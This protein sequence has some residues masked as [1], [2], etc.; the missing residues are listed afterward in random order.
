[1]K[2]TY[3]KFFL[4]T[5]VLGMLVSS[6]NPKTPKT[7]VCIGDSITEGAGVENQSLHSFPSVLSALLGPDYAVINCGQ[8]GATMLTK[9]DLPYETTNEWY[10][11]Q[12][13]MADLA[14][15]ALG[16]NDSKDHNW[17]LDRFADNYRLM[18]ETMLRQNPEMKIYV[19]L[20]PPAFNH[21]WNIN[22]STIRN[23]VI[24]VVR[25][26]AQEM[27][28]ELI[29][30]YSPLSSRADLFPDGIHP[31]EKGYELIAKLIE[32]EIVSNS[33]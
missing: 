1:M 10:N 31:N 12:A 22:D 16:T 29:D 13:S 5:V 19:C 18:L 14:I 30:L 27:N 23:G 4:T 6:C 25:R 3:F 28:L 20:P 11:A 24:P 33:K 26:L 9:S 7:L 21:N 8:G 32:K 17:N 2:N 15:I